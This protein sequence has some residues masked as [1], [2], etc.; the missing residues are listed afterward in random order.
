MDDHVIF[1]LDL[2]GFT[3]GLREPNS[4]SAVILTELLTNLASLRGDFDLIEDKSDSGQRFN[5]RAAVST[6]S[7]H[8]VISCPARELERTGAG[9]SSALVLAE[10]LI[11]IFAARAIDWV[12]SFVAA[13]RWDPYTTRAALS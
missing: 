13:R 2:L 5:I 7:D 11:S 4:K 8:V 1:Y 3:A 9:L 10:K 12:C 6:F